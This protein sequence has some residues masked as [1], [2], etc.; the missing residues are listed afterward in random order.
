MI[1]WILLDTLWKKGLEPR[2]GLRRINRRLRML[3]EE[4]R[5]GERE[6]IDTGGTREGWK[7]EE[8]ETEAE[9]DRDRQRE[10]ERKNTQWLK[11]EQPWQK[12]RGEGCL[13]VEWVQQT[14]LSCEQSRP[15]S[16]CSTKES[17][18]RLGQWLS[19]YKHLLSQR[20][21]AQSPA[22]TSDILQTAVPIVPGDR[23]LSSVL[24]GHLHSHS[25]HTHTHTPKI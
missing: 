14:S 8:G 13:S 3:W 25:T 2:E 1:F 18:G 6:K 19:G 10:T 16:Y 21:W 24:C 20:I 4:W 15:R 12:W 7:G 5:G 9:R 23:M 22:P 17:T 11:P